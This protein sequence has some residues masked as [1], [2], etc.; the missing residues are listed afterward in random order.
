MTHPQK[1]SMI[2]TDGAN[3][4]FTLLCRGFETCCL[5]FSVVSVAA[6]LQG[7][8]TNWLGESNPTRDEF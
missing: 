2:L 8:T 3:D 6:V 1:A 5:I 4:S 7:G